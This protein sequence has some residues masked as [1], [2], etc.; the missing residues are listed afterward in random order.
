LEVLFLVFAGKGGAGEGRQFER[1]CWRVM[2]R[3]LW[4]G[5]EKMVAGIDWLSCQSLLLAS[6]KSSL[7]S[8]TLL[9]MLQTSLDAQNIQ[10]HLAL[11]TPFSPTNLFY[12]PPRPSPKF[13]SKLLRQAF[14][15]IMRFHSGQQS[16]QNS[17]EII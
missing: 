17:H 16:C 10:M 3:S 6:I 15:L 2:N 5:G 13:P 12:L 7:Q 11:D 9:L 4:M 14:L 1:D 8:S